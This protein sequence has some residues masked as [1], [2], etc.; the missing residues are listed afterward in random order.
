MRDMLVVPWRTHNTN[1]LHGNPIEREPRETLF[2][3]LIDNNL[4]HTPICYSILRNQPKGDTN[5]PS[6]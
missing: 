2:N 4:L 3:I 1:I 6:L 5:H